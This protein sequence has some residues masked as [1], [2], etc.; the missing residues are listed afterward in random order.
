MMTKGGE[1]ERFDSLNKLMCKMME[2]TVCLQYSLQL[3]WPQQIIR[4]EKMD[5]QFRRFSIFNLS[6]SPLL[7][8]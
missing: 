8:F 4:T 7:K 3:G 2:A 5:E 1:T 6:S